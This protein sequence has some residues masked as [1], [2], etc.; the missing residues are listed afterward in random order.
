MK[1]ITVFLVTALLSLSFAN[2]PDI[3][4]LQ[5]QAGEAVK[6]AAELT[7]IKEIVKKITPIQFKVGSSSLSLD[8]PDFK[9]AGQDANQ[10]MKNVVIPALSDLI[11]RVPSDKQI[12]I[13]GHASST[14]SDESNVALSQK[15]AEA[16]LA[17]F[18]SN[19]ELSEN[20]FMIVA[21]GSSLTLPGFDS[22]DPKNCRVGF[23]LN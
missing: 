22:D 16:V 5:K 1:M 7:A 23:D 19:S 2:F 6:Q 13:I 11:N 21:K 9:I 14:G 12:I 18:K 3:N 17:Y 10:L 20:K 15:R 8:D 4:N